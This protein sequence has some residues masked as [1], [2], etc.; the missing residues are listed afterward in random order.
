MKPMHLQ[1]LY[2]KT[3]YYG[4]KVAEDIFNRGVCLPSGSAL[5]TEELDFIVQKVSEGIKSIL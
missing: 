5:T 2:E 3:P 1:P 4:E